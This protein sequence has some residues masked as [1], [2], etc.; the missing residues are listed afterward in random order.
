ML[1]VGCFC[2]W[3]ASLTPVHALPRINSYQNYRSLN[4]LTEQSGPGHTMT[5]LLIR[6]QES[7]G[8][9]LYF[10]VMVHSAPKNFRQR[11][12]IRETWGSVSSLQGWQVRV[13]FLLGLAGQ[14]SREKSR[15]QD[16]N[17]LKSRS[18]DSNA[19]LKSS[20]T[21]SQLYRSES[22]NQLVT[23]ESRLHRDIVQGNFS[24][25][26]ESLTQKHVMGY[27]WVT[28]FCS[29]PRFVLKTDDDVFVEMYHLFNFVNAVYGSSPGPS[30]VCDVIPAG[31][32]HHRAGKW[33]E[34]HRLFPKYCSGSAYLVTPSLVSTFLKATEEVPSLRMDDVY[35]TGLV[36]ERLGV[37]PF[38]LNLRYSYQQAR[39]RKWV[40]SSKR[41]PLPFIFVVSSGDDRDWPELV[42]S[43][44]RKSTELQSDYLI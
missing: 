22:V 2:L 41:S 17:W 21:A 8:S 20:S 39:A 31:T 44:W 3:L 4:T 24:D 16:D 38:Y 43:L 19:F 35:M 32:S 9:K 34:T 18:L 7:C 36:R 23:L 12:L 10:L 25:N 42:R 30:L 15:S 40:R 6:P 5:Q 29:T 1:W 28:D 27:R 26:V 11:D 13:V 14:E 37:S 33:K